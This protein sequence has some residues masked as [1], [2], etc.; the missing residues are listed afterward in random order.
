MIT[1]QVFAGLAR[2]DRFAKIL[3]PG[4]R[5]TVAQMRNFFPSLLTTGALCGAPLDEPPEPVQFPLLLDELPLELPI[6]A[7]QPAVVPPP[8]PGHCQSQAIR[9]L[10]TDEGMPALQR[11]AAAV[12]ALER[13]WFSAVPHTPLKVV[14]VV[15]LLELPLDEVLVVPELLPL[16]LVDPLPELPVPLLEPELEL[17][18]PTSASQPVV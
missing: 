13:L 10:V 8:V 9:L 12:G 15:P 11:L 18:L 16:G 5:A 4:S 17:E 6:K 1:T 7:S 3:N 14:T 2:G